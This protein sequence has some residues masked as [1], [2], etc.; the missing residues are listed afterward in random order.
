MKRKSLIALVLAPLVAFGGIAIAQAPQSDREALEAIGA[1]LVDQGIVLPTTTQPPTTTTE[2]PTTTT[3]APTT[4]TTAAPTTTT[5]PATTTSTGPLPTPTGEHYDFMVNVHEV[6]QAWVAEYY[7]N[8]PYTDDVGWGYGNRDGYKCMYGILLW[9]DDPVG[10]FR[11][12]AV[13]EAQSYTIIN[14]RKMPDRG[15][16]LRHYDTGLLGSESNPPDTVRQGECPPPDLAYEPSTLPGQL[17]VIDY[18]GPNGE[19]L[20]RRDYQKL[21]DLDPRLKFR[22][23][24]ATSQVVT[25]VAYWENVPFAVVYYDS[26][27]GGGVTMD[28]F[29]P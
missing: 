24:S 20:E 27:Y 23:H 26:P 12:A 22:L 5:A 29:V 1:I 3:A 7:L 4:T 10:R 6:G 2:P 8:L 21:V 28:A 14:D 15:P 25:V 17:P 11:V 13:P 9:D 16:L 18:L 19:L